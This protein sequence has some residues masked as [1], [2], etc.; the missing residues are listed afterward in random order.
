MRQRL[1]PRR[2]SGLRETPLS[3]AEALA[4]VAS[5]LEDFRLFAAAAA[6]ADTDDDES[7]A[8]ETFV[9]TPICFKKSAFL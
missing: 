7:P 3:S 1:Q 9:S 4:A 6:A 8:N 5:L 2:L